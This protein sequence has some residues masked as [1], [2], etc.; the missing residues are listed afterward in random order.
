MLVGVSYSGRCGIIDPK[1]PAI[2]EAI[3]KTIIHRSSVND[4]NNWPRHSLDETVG[5]Y[6]QWHA[7]LLRGRYEGMH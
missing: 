1:F 2:A 3:V 7:S 4:L 6:I 5:Y